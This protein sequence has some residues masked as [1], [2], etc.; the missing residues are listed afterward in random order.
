ELRPSGLRFS[1][2]TPRSDWTNDA[3]ARSRS[4]YRRYTESG[5]GS[6]VNRQGIVF[7]T[8]GGGRLPI[9]Q[10]LAATLAEREAIR[11]G[12]K[13][14]AA[15]ARERGLNEKYLGLLWAMLN[16]RP[17]C[18][19]SG[20]R[21]APLLD[22]LRAQWRAARD[23]EAAPLAA[24]SAASRAPEPVDLAQLARTHDVDAETVAAWL[25][26][27]GLGPAEPVKLAHFS[28]KQTS[29]AG[30]AFIQGWG[31]PDLPSVVTNSSDQHVR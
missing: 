5:G 24:A 23:G 13:S 22:P 1:P 31:S 12:K 10:Y 3:L 7:N 4:F 29:G 20:T 11:A 19:P 18:L 9:E 16:D 28:T 2:H 25:E 27:L 6:T 26:Y 15:V 21:P 17:G 30:Y 14:V 8:N